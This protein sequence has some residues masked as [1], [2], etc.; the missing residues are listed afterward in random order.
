MH[1]E[2]ATVRLDQATEGVLVAGLC[3]GQQKA[4]IG[5]LARLGHHCS[6]GQTVLGPETNRSVARAQP[7][8]SRSPMSFT[9]ADR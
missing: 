3:R 7:H 8:Q 9:A 6:L 1:L 2:R 4:L 5:V